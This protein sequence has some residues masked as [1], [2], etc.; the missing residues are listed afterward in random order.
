M[1]SL[2]HSD[3]C[4]V[5][6]MK[7]LEPKIAPPNFPIRPFRDWI[8]T[9]I[10]VSD[11]YKEYSDTFLRRDVQDMYLGAKWVW[12]CLTRNFDK[13]IERLAN[14]ELD[15]T[16]KAIGRKREDY[17]PTQL[18]QL[19]DVKAKHIAANHVKVLEQIFAAQVF[20]TDETEFRTR[21]DTSSGVRKISIMEMKKRNGILDEDDT[22]FIPR[23]GDMCASITKAALPDIAI[24]ST[25]NPFPVGFFPRGMGK[26]DHMQTLIDVSLR[27]G[28]LRNNSPTRILMWI[29]EQVLA[30]R[31]YRLGLAHHTAYIAT[32]PYSVKP[33]TIRATFIGG[34]DN[35][36]E[37]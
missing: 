25:P 32:P 4:K 26:S 2:P 19:L 7:P 35:P 13:R 10:G 33:E 17:V 15:K 28:I 9:T 20:D 16:L 34:K 29:K 37:T 1:I 30:K 8:Q 22:P 27:E 31:E 23:I 24:A 21:V 3:I 14:E 12:S 36:L 11:V 18:K 6:T 5:L